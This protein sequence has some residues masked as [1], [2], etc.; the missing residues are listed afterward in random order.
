MGNA[1]LRSASKL[2]NTRKKRTRWHRFVQ[3]MA[4]LVVFC[5]TYALILPAITMEG[6]MACGLNEHTHS[7]SC[8]SQLE[9]RMWT[10]PTDAVVLHSH[11]EGCVDG[12]GNLICPL[13]EQFPH[14]HEDGC[15]EEENLIC[16]LPER[17]PHEHGES[18]YEEDALICP[19]PRVIFHQHHDGCL[20]LETRSVMTCEAPEHTH[21]DSCYPAE[22]EEPQ[23]PAYLCGQGAHSH[24]ESCFDENGTLICSIPEHEHQALCQVAGLDPTADLESSSD[25]DAIGRQLART[26]NW[27]GDLLAMAISQVGYQESATNV[28]LVNGELQGYSRYG[29]WAGNGY[30]PWDDVFIHFCMHYAGIP[31]EAIPRSSDTGWWIS[32]LS[33]KQL[34]TSAADGLPQSGSIV[35][36]KDVQGRI[37][38]AVV[39]GAAPDQTNLDKLCYRV[40]AGDVE[41]QVAVITVDLENILL[42]CDVNNA[43]TVYERMLSGET[44]ENE[45]TE[46]AAGQESGTNEEISNA[47]SVIDLAPPAPPATDLTPSD[48][49]QVPEDT[50][51]AEGARATVTYDLTVAD[52]NNLQT[53]VDYI[54]YRNAGSNITLMGSD[55][56][57]NPI[58]VNVGSSNAYNIGGKWTMTPGQVNNTDVNQ[59][60][61]QVEKRNN[62]TFLVS[63]STGRRLAINRNGIAM[64]NNGTAL[65]FRVNG[66]S[67][68]INGGDPWLQ[69]NNNDWGMGWY[70]GEPVYFAR[71]STTQAEANYPHAVH[72]GEVHINRLRF[73]NVSEN[74]NKGVTYLAGCVFE[75]AGE[76]GYTATITSGNGPE[77]MLPSDIPDGNYTITEISTPEGYVRDAEYR[78]S[79]VIKDGALASDGTIGT[80]INHSMEQLVA[81]K[82]A[83]VEDY[84]NRIYQINLHA[85]SYLEVYEMDPIDLLFVVDQSNSMLFPSGLV[86]TGKRVTLT[87]SG[88]NNAANME[89]LNLDK[90]RMHYVIADPNGTSTVWAVWHDG[91]AWMCQDA[92]YYAKAKHNNDPGYQDDNETVIFPSNLSYSEQADSEPDGVRSNGCGLGK[93]LGNSSLGKYIG[94]LGGSGTFVVYQSTDEYNRLHYLEESLANLIYEMADVND[95]NRITLT[96]FSRYVDEANCIGPLELTPANADLLRAAVTSIKTSGGTRQ[97]RA[98]EHVYIEHLNDAADKYKDFDH[99]YTLLITDGAPVRSGDDQPENVGSANDP[100]NKNG[101]SIYGRIKGHAVDVRSKSHLMTVAL[102][103]ESVYAGKQVL[104]DIATDGSFY[105]ALDDASALLQSIQRLLFE[106]F[107]PKGEITLYGDIEDEISNSFYPIAWVG[108]NQT[109]ANRLLVESGDRNWVLLNENDWIT[110]EGQLTTAGAADAAGQLLKREDGTYFVRWEEQSVTR[111]WKGT[112]YVKAKEDFIGGN[113]IDTNKEASVS[114]YRDVEEGVPQYLGEKTFETPTV[115]VHLLDMNENHSE[116]TVYLG[117]L[118]NGGSGPLDTLRGFYEN[119]KF[120]KLISDSGHILNKVSADSALGLEAAVFYLRYAMGRDLTEEEWAK[121]A[122][123]DT[124]TVPYTYDDASSHGA[125]G[126]FTFRLSK[127]GMGSSYS[128]HKSVEACQIGGLPLT[129]NC[130]TPVETYTLHITYD[131]YRLGEAGRPAANVRNGPDGP[132][133]EVG[134]GTILTNGLGTIEK[135]NV[136]EVHVISGIIEVTK[137]FDDSITDEADRT[138]TFTLHRVDDGTDTSRDVTKNITIPAGSTQGSETIRFEN[139]ARGTYTVTEA[140][141]E[142]YALKSITVLDSTNAYSEPPPGSS[143]IHLLTVMGHDLDYRDVIGKADPDDAYTSYINPVNGVYAAVRFTNGPITYTAEL[144]VEKIWDAIAGEYE[145][146]QVYLVLCLDDAPVLDGNGNARLIRL[147]AQNNWKGS[148]LIHLADENDSLENYNYSVREVTQVRNEGVQ[149][150]ISAILENDGTT[151]LYYERAVEEGRLFTMDGKGYAVHYDVGSDGRLTVTNSRAVEL[152]ATG[153]IGTIPLYT[154]GSLLVTAAACIGGYD[155]RRKQR[156]EAD[157]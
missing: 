104:E 139:L 52:P 118:V 83:E 39:Y 112:F 2:N 17:I 34:L 28:T 122:N 153:G 155:R 66:A 96:R 103:M 109:T 119:T 19:M 13:A 152:P 38:P 45:P 141:D 35:F 105:C 82:D 58:Q 68:E 5:T 154:M 20:K 138:F 33:E 6:S 142:E 148:F 128:E 136:H 41:G 132:G 22:V 3:T 89:A 53:G 113:A 48:G 36:A 157:A 69:Y 7:E 42:I 76:N 1:M 9:E 61:W 72:T 91:T 54:I 156:R 43:R 24:S 85:D 32:L 126:E 145:D 93:D 15:F 59:I 46:P 4:M 23:A 26:D 95:Q 78:R 149:D 71:I 134:T 107:R 87:Q 117:D 30:Q 63:K 140:V 65:G 146:G 70:N 12:D 29:D 79:F 120:E 130:E 121:L 123:G 27:A 106:S 51:T 125:V 50:V 97:D 60:I 57:I 75:I 150:W 80:F 25:W 73:F 88:A 133:T 11:D 64:N 143:G 92:S 40:V 94:N 144:P 55:N 108:K 90:S 16:Q 129:D 21:S 77:V 110:L 111:Y 62:Q 14:S 124:I 18:C 147:D 151:L 49:I 116:V 31:Q 101:N 84:A 47:D 98:L 81:S 67:T 127:T 86:D 99:S 135:E 115:N 74:G 102:G 137:V 100:A 56:N 37:F 8:Y 10:C 131:A 114:I 44:M